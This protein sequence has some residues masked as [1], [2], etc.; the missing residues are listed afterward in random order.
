MRSFPAL[1]Y[2]SFYN[3]IRQPFFSLTIVGAYIFIL[4]SPAFTMF[5]RPDGSFTRGDLEIF[6]FDVTGLCYVWGLNHARI[7]KNCLTWVDQNGK[8]YIKMLINGVKQGAI[9]L[10]TQ[11]YDA[12]KLY[13]ATSVTKEGKTYI[14]G[15]G[16]FL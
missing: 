15:S 6:V 5:T 4:S 11:E 7:W 8:P 1:T 10:T 9:T 3:A 13:Y 12:Q 14:V 16:F 2:V